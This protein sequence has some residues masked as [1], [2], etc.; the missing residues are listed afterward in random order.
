MDIPASRTTPWALMPLERSLN[1]K[2]AAFAASWVVRA[3][4][5]KV[6]FSACR[7]ESIQPGMPEDAD[8]LRRPG[9]IELNRISE[10]TLK[11][12]AK[13]HKRKLKIKRKAK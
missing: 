11:D 1:K 13:K 7:K 2:T 8:V 10:N 6:A 12:L 5:L 3:F 9:F 4:F